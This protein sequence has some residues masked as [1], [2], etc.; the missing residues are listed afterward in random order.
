MVS[1]ARLCPRGASSPSSALLLVSAA[2]L[3]FSTS[4]SILF[5]A[6]VVTAHD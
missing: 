2:A 3:I 4:W 5:T 6:R 1:I